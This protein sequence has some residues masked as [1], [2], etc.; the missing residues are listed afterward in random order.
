MVIKKLSF[1]FVLG[2]AVLTACKDEP[3]LALEEQ[4][5]VEA[6]QSIDASHSDGM[7]VLGQELQDPYKLSN[8][9]Q[10]YANITG[11]KAQLQPTH[12]YMRFLPKNEEEL[13]L[14]KNI[15]L[16]NF[17]L[18]YEI[19][20][21]GDCYHDPELPAEAITWQYAVIPI[22]T[23]IPENI[24]HELIYEVFIPNYDT[25]GSKSGLLEAIEDEAIRLCGYSDMLQQNASKGL[26]SK[27]TPSGTIKVWDDVLL[28]Y[29]PIHGAKVQVRWLTHIE[30]DFTDANG[31]FSTSSFRFDVNYSIKWER[32]DFDIRSGNWG[33]AWYNGPKLGSAWYLNIDK[34]GMSWVYAHIFRAAH[35]YYY[36]HSSWGIKSPPKDGKLL[37]QSIKIGAMDKSGT[38]HYFDFN[39]FFTTPQIK[40]FRYDSDGSEQA[41]ID[42]FAT[43]IHEL[44]HASHWEMCYDYGQYVSDW[45]INKAIVPESWAKCVEYVIT[46]DIYAR[47]NRRYLDNATKYSGSQFYP[48]SYFKKYPYTPIFIDCIDDYNQREVK[49][50]NT[51]YPID[52]VSG[53]ILS[54]IEDA[55][56]FGA[57]DTTASGL[58]AIIN[59]LRRFDNPTNIY[60]EELFSNYRKLK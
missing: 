17:P 19:I 6:Q 37:K 24:Q 18:H 56:K 8:M 3:M 32:A 9:Q 4:Q 52:R 22:D 51:N 33:Q 30:K 14:L 12:R 49:S 16:F 39:K 42:L 13:Y 26:F 10:A 40:V 48:I 35:M 20:Q 47:Y 41:S 53:Y 45:F 60:L 28:K 38:S 11:A 55:I 59:G 34:G 57:T 36:G 31:N 25:D 2:L 44:A 50:N 27:W 58:K 7:M 5:N 54:Q 1:A 21:N 29:I 23:R 15:D 46:N 43:T